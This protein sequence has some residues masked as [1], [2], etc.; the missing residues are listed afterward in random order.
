MADADADAAEFGA[1]ACVDRP[2][3]IVA[4]RAAAD[5]HLHLERREVELVVE[6]GQGVHVELVELQR[7][8]NGIAAVVHEGL[9][10]QEQDALPADA[11]LRD[12]A[13]ELL[14]TRTESRALRR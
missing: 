3:S 9:R 7:L 14:L 1:E 8:L 6:D 10:L 4:R 13:P 5:L 2:Q 12:Q 11:A